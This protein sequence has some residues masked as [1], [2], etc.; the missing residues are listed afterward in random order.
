ML[1]E[2]SIERYVEG[3]YVFGGE[4]RLFLFSNYDAAASFAREVRRIIRADERDLGAE[5]RRRLQ[6]LDNEVKSE[7]GLHP[8]RINITAIEPLDSA[9]DAIARIDFDL[10]SSS[11]QHSR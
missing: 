6:W 7:D 11:N 2:V 1:W 4:V 9:K 8:N 5:D 10:A 3:G